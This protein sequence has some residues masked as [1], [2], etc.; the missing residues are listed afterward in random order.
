MSCNAK[1]HRRNGGRRRRKGY[2]RD[3]LKE[4]VQREDLLEGGCD[5]P[6]I[7][8]SVEFT[9]L[10]IREEYKQFRNLE[11]CFLYDYVIVQHP[12]MDID[13]TAQIMEIEWDLFA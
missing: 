11:N 3:C 2:R 9:N 5:S 13:V 8:M 7:E 10:E 6:K 12:T 1:L 4:D